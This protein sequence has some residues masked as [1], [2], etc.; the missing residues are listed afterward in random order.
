MAASVHK[1]CNRIDK[2]KDEAGVRRNK[3]NGVEI[4]ISQFYQKLFTSTTG[5]PSTFLCDVSPKFTEEHK[6]TLMEPFTTEDVKEALFAIHPDKSS[7]L[8]G[9]NPNFFQ[10]HWDIIKEDL[11]RFCL[12]VIETKMLPAELHRTAIV[13]IPKMK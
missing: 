7:G 11:V 9:M 6:I 8:D 10:S 1:R 5:D 2:L 3:D 12:S 4:L 13:L